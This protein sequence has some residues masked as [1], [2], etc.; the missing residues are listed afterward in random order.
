MASTALELSG[1]AVVEVDRMRFARDSLSGNTLGQFSE[2]E[3]ELTTV[4]QSN[5]DRILST[6]VP[7]ASLVLVCPFS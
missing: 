4:S 2:M 3:Y 7:F 6:Q 1:N 5:L